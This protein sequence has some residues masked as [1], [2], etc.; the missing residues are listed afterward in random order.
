MSGR[1]VPGPHDRH[2]ELNEALAGVWEVGVG[3]GDP[4]LEELMGRL[5]AN[6]LYLKR[7]LPDELVAEED[8]RVEHLYA[9]HRLHVFLPAQLHLGEAEELV[10]GARR[11][12]VFDCGLFT[13]IA[14]HCHSH[15]WI[16]QSGGVLTGDVA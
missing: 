6:L 16:A 2:G 12:A 7:E 11:L 1:G 15:K 3:E 10:E 9:D 13:K 14:R 5:V 8:V 4:R